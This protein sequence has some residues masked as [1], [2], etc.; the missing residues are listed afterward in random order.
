MPINFKNNLHTSE[1][2]GEVLFFGRAHC[3]L[4][5]KALAHLKR[6]GFNVTSIFSKGR[7]ESLPEDIGWWSGDYIFCFR[8]MFILPK[9][10]ID[11]AKVAA[12]N[13]HPGPPEYPGSGCLNYALYEDSKSYGVTAHLM[14]EKVDD[15]NI[16]EC[17]RF[18][19]HKS[20]TVDSL[21]ER[22]HVKLLDLFF[23]T[24]SGISSSKEDYLKGS[25]E[26]SKNEEWSGV[27]RKIK[28]LDALSVIDVNITNNEIE[29][30]IRATF[31]ENFPP[32]I[33]IHGYEFIL[34][35]SKQK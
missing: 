6:L 3:D 2:N 16:I 20:D 7:G 26:H 22:T 17:R 24:T 9:Y 31:T 12:I 23:D 5:S 30:I 11:R 35:S 34:K 19:I 15:G 18:Q 13:F 33:I 8:S 4:S 14:N 29:K 32:K 10:L 28:D 27:N 1:G 21:L 25:L